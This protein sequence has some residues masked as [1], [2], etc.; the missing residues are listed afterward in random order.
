MKFHTLIGS[1]G[2]FDAFVEVFTTDAGREHDGVQNSLLCHEVC[3]GTPIL[4]LPGLFHLRENTDF[5]FVAELVGVHETP[6]IWE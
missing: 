2:I 4:G 6:F 3:A 1:F 5:H